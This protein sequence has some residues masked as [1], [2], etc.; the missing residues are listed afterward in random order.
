VAR[1]ADGTGPGTSVAQLAS[2][3]Y[4]AAYAEVFTALGAGA[5]V[6]VPDDETRGDPAAL[7]RWLVA[8]S[9]G[10]V[11]LIP[12]LFVEVLNYLPDELRRVDRNALDS[13]LLASPCSSASPA[14]TA[15][16]T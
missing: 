12:S 11:V 8:E 9:V 1:R 6:R 16:S 10:L 2:R 3:S 4:D 7:A 15:R 14:P 13:I 5:T